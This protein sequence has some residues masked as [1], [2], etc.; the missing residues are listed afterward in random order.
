VSCNEAYC[1]IDCQVSR[2]SQWGSCSTTCE[3]GEQQ[4]SR[5]AVLEAAFG[6]NKCPKKEQTRDCNVYN[7]CPKHCT[8]SKWG[9]WGAC[10]A[11]CGEGSQRRART[12]TAH[13]NHGGYSCPNLEKTRVCNTAPCP[14][15]CVL[16]DWGSWKPFIR[17]GA[18]V[19][20]MRQIVRAPKFGG[21]ECEHRKE[22]KEY[23]KDAQM[24]NTNTYYGKWSECTKQCG[25]G[26]RY[27]F[28]EH[29]ICSKS[30][31]VKY[32]MKFR[33]GERCNTQNCE[34]GS[35]G[36]VSSVIIPEVSGALFPQTAQAATLD[37]ELREQ[38]IY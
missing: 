13:A 4:R 32:H 36:K 26:V 2:W 17:G 25:S 38:R 20:R 11:S 30:A 8:V 33:Q 27:R 31:V 16:S 29:V 12:I 18:K 37:E 9:D 19:R 22:Y 21:V 7:P 1:P 6:G 14:I 10:T 5:Y 23:T 34:D 28:R 24:C 3:K 35:S 15:N